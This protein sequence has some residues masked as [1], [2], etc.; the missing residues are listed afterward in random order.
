MS[1]AKN[2]TH[3]SSRGVAAT[4]LIC[5]VLFSLLV[6]GGGK[7][8]ALRS[9]VLSAYDGGEGSIISDLTKHNENAY[10]IITVGK[11]VL[12]ADDSAITDAEAAYKA[13]NVASTPA[14]KYAAD[15]QLD[16]AITYL[17]SAMNA[18][19][20]NDK[21]KTLV[22]GQKADM[23]SRDMIISH[24]DYNERVFEYAQAVSS[25]PGNLIAV[26]RGLGAPGYYR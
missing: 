3:L 15:Q 22:T 7:L 24:S 13:M 20:M 25:F 6:L 5:C 26:C 17:V 23:D 21:D 18:A 19:G 14:D 11:R 1:G 8:S 16:S 4:F 12:G 10:N 2:K 9:D